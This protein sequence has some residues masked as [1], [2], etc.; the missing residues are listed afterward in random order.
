[1]RKF[2]RAATAGIVFISTVL[3]LL[4]VSK[5]ESQNELKDR[6]GR[7]ARWAAVVSPNPA[8]TQPS[9]QSHVISEKRQKVVEV[10]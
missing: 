3:L 1:M 2:I 10:R 8:V 6:M 5:L 9:T 4:H 7:A